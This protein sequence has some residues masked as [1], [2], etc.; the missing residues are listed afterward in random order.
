MN[1]RSTIIGKMQKWQRK[2]NPES[3]FAGST[4]SDDEISNDSN[5][6]KNNSKQRKQK[7]GLDDMSTIMGKM[8]KYSDAITT[9]GYFS[10]KEIDNMNVFTSME[11]T[12]HMLCNI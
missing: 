5:V 4:T 9:K 10:T 7:S 11:E 8:Q 12:G 3:D 6:L 1:K 2:Q